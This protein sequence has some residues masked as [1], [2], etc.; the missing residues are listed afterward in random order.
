M[1]KRIPGQQL[2]NT[3]TKGDKGEEI[4]GT[5]I[6]SEVLTRVTDPE[7]TDD[8]LD[9][10]RRLLDKYKNPIVVQ[11]QD[12]IRQEL[13]QHV[14][15]VLCYTPLVF[16]V[17][18]SDKKQILYAKIESK[19]LNENDELQQDWGRTKRKNERE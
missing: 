1:K 14:S 3:Y 13:Q 4:S 19:K 15:E 17:A 12:H 9:K 18:H 10:I 8:L 2:H 7:T 16:V 6:I 5:S 11:L